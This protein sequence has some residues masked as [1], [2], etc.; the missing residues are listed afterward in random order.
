MYRKMFS[1]VMVFVISFG[2]MAA[3]DGHA[4]GIFG[5]HK[6]VS[7]VGDEVR[8]PIK[9]IDDGDA[10][11]YEYEGG[12]TDIKFFVVKS[13]DGVLRAAFDACDVCFS[14]KKGYTQDGDFMIC[15]NCGR[16]FHS[17]QINVVEG[18][19]NPAPLHRE[20]VGDNLVIKI[21]D[22]LPGARFF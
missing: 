12:G 15:N 22:I 11:Y 16:R 4:F 8:I 17:S 7:A 20:M 6:S 9:D 21:E 2:V 5:Q 18:G 10:H 3:S 1:I 13:S 19:C 14:A